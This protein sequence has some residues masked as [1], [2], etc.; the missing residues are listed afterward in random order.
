[1]LVAAP[2]T[3]YARS[4]DVNVAYQVIEGDGP[5]DVVFVHG[6]VSNMEVQAEQPGHEAWFQQLASVGRVIRFDRRGTGLSDRVRE[7]P[8]LETR[9]D[10]LRAVMDAVS[11]RRAAV[12][13]TFEA[14]SMAMVYAATYP[15]RVAAL[16]LYNPTAK[17]VR[18]PD[19]PWPMYSEKEWESW[20]GQ[21]PTRWGTRE[22][23]TEFLRDSA[24]SIAGDPEMQEWMARVHRLGA[25]P[26][27]AEV[28]LRMMMT[29]D[30]RDVL[31]SIRV[32]TLVLYRA[33]ARGESAYVAERIPGARAVE[34]VGPDLMFWLA[35]GLAD[36]II[37]FFRSITEEPVPDTVLATILFTDIVDSSAKAVELGDR[38]WADLVQRHHAAVRAQ[39]DRFHGRELDTA[40]D[41]F[42]A[43]FDGPIRAIRCATAIRTAV[44]DLGLDVRAGLHAGECEVVGEKLGGVAVIV[45]ARV[46][47]LADAGEILVSSTVKDLVAG[48]GIEFEDR[49]V[50]TLK[51][52]PDEWRLFAVAPAV[53]GDRA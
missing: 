7:V 23:A 9:M 30:V 6:F 2:I 18:S 8:T 13:A 36:E 45:G 21:I 39:L 47:A 20:I 35:E 46:A 19:Y 41:A 24:P 43:A 28:I 12:V 38:A 16:A 53:D 14:A 22:F 3:R 11:S 1:V 5:L 37:T 44:G 51:G 42:F 15:E 34:I 52:L 29:V 31:P 48:S 26:G 4:G 17:G 25:S 40:G 49:G 32:P 50:A 27:A 10:D 33:F